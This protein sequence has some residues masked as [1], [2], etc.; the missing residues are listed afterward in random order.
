MSTSDFSSCLA[1]GMASDYYEIK[2]TVD[3]YHEHAVCGY[4]KKT[5]NG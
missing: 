5:E 1:F 4:I 3:I 2:K